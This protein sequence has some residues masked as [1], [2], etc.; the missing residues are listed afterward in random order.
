M[1]VFREII[2]AFNDAERLLTISMKK[3]DRYDKAQA[4][5]LKLAAKAQAKI[6]KLDAKAQAKILKLDAKA[7][8]KILKLDAKA[9]AKRVKI[10]F[11]NVKKEMKIIEKKNKKS[12][13][14]KIREDR[15]KEV[16]EMLMREHPHGFSASIFTN[17]FREIY[18]NMNVWTGELNDNDYD[19]NAGIRSLLYEMSP[20]S[21]QHWFK[22][23]I[24]H[25]E[26]EVA[27]WYFINKSLAILNNKYE[28]K[29]TTAGT[30]RG[31]RKEKG[32]W[33]YQPYLFKEFWSV[34]NYGPLPTEEMLVNAKLGRRIGVRGAKV[35]QNLLPE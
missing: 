18:G 33:I 21:S 34:E 16:G 31:G 20:S 24:G 29:N 28:W 22:Y 19:T 5:I 7:Q 6:L 2:T 32:N 3:S 25:K 12:E 17:K 14:K 26:K 9:Q 11:N 27:K 23:G 10:D 4:K 35:V 15:M 1:S 13:A 8:A 30:G